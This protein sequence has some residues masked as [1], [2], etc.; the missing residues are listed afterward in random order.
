[1]GAGASLKYANI[2]RLDF[3][4]TFL[5]FWNLQNSILTM[6]YLDGT[7][8]FYSS[9]HKLYIVDG[10]QLLLGLHHFIHNLPNSNLT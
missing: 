6:Y 1:M 5:R 7:S 8:L 4:V 10:K 9:V 2:R 3:L